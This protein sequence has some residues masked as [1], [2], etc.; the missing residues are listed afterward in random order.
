MNVQCLFRISYFSI[1][2]LDDNEVREKTLIYY[3]YIFIQCYVFFACSFVFI[4]LK[5]ILMN[6]VLLFIID[7]TKNDGKE[8]PSFSKN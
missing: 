8:I 3:Y 2:L 5:N 7:L 1:V 4:G 6:T